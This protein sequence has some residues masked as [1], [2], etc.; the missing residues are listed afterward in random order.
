[1]T[2]FPPGGPDDGADWPFED[3]FGESFAVPGGLDD[4]ALST[5]ALE[6]GLDDAALD[7]AAL[8]DT[9]LDDAAL[10]DAALRNAELED[11]T[12][13]VSAADDIVSVLDSETLIQRRDPD[14]LLWAL[15]LS[16]AQVRQAVNRTDRWDR[17]ALLSDLPPRAVLIVTD[18]PAA[19][20]AAVLAQLGCERVP[21]LDWRAPELPRWAGPTDVLLAASVDGRHPRVATL[22]ADAERR[23]L[24]VVAVSPEDS[25]VAAAAGRG[26]RIPVDPG[27]H[28][29]AAWWA[30]LAPLL[31]VLD[32]LGVL[33]APASM[34]TELADDLDSVAE[35][36]RPG[37]DAFTN[38]AKQLAIEFAD[39]E[40]I[41]AGCGPLSRLAAGQWAGSLARLA[42]I[43]SVAVGLPEDT[44]TAGALL[45]LPP[46]G[47]GGAESDEDDGFF[48]D[49]T[50]SQARRRR[51]VVIT[52]NG[53]AAP[54]W[55]EVGSS[56]AGADLHELAAGRAAGALFDTAAARGLVSSTLDVPG[57]RPLARFATATLFGDFVATYLAI[58]RGVDPAAMRAGELPH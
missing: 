11:S 54:A 30:I 26:V 58:G 50:E 46:G 38:A 9:A 51:L 34:L 32:L 57:Q 47:P 8:D 48:R 27:T 10:D 15:A 52:E 40:P 7:D 21:V 13:D 44:A 28:R 35:S 23:G 25:P 2:T 31:L 39:T 53:P 20:A 24:T 12:L 4:A 14:R 41:L 36:A 22:L 29:R 17:A 43:G 33:D 18:P 6:D 56:D 3:P 45:E 16:G 1:M 49:R 5:G 42:G 19:I 55:P 37:T